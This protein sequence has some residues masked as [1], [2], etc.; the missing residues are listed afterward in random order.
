METTPRAGRCGFRTRL[1][2]TDFFLLQNIQ[3][4]SGAHPTSYSI[5]TVFLSRGKAAGT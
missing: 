2:A 5:G 3:T 4:G 1:G